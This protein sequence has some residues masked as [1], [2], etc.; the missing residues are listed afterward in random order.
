M[1]KLFVYGTLLKGRPAHFLLKKCKFAGKAVARH[2]ALYRVEEHFP[3]AV[4]EA[5]SKVRGELYEV[6]DRTLAVLDKY[7]GEEF[8]RCRVEVE[9]EGG[10]VCEAWAYL[11]VGG[12]VGS[13]RISLK[14]QPWQSN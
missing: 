13:K 2:L 7:E 10:E 14:E 5:G 4:A 8:C 12:T 11:W 9:L 3:G 1:H 6:K